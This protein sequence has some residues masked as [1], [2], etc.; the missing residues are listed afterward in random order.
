MFPWNKLLCALSFCKKMLMMVYAQKTGKNA[1]DDTSECRAGITQL[2][3][4]QRKS[5]SILREREK[6]RLV[7]P[8]CSWNLLSRA[9]E[10]S[11]SWSSHLETETGVDISAFTDIHTAINKTAWVTLQHLV[12]LSHVWW[13]RNEPCNKY[14]VTVQLLSF[15][16]V[17]A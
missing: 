7:L 4:R 1:Q 10:V 3:P 12:L 16:F 17:K 9:A 15:W 14:L 2:W 8:S 11:L 5:V 13:S 6:E